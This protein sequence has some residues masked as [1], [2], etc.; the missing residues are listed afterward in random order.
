MHGRQYDGHGPAIAISPHPDSMP[1]SQYTSSTL[2]VSHSPKDNIWTT[3]N[4]GQHQ[5]IVGNDMYIFI[6]VSI[7]GTWSS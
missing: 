5:S 4:E 3:G 1:H 2:S 7:Q 6:M